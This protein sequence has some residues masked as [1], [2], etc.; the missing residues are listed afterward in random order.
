LVAAVL[1]VAAAV[2]CGV[3]SKGGGGG[4]H[5]AVGGGGGVFERVKGREGGREIYRSM[6]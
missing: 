2:R 5:G 3:E 6:D 4:C 1:T